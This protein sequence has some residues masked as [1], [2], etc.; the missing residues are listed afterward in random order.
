MCLGRTKLEM[1]QT[2]TMALCLGG[3][4]ML[5]ACD[6]TSTNGNSTDELL[7]TEADRRAG[8]DGRTETDRPV[9]DRPAPVDR[10]DGLIDRVEGID[11]ERVRNHLFEVIEHCGETEGGDVR[12]RCQVLRHRAAGIDDATLKRRVIH[13]YLQCIR[14]EVRPP[15]SGPCDHIRA[16]AAEVEDRLLQAELY[17]DFFECQGDRPDPVRDRCQ[18]IRYRAA[19][20]RD[21]ALRDRVYAHYF[22]C[23]NGDAPHPPTAVCQDLRARAASIT[24]RDAA[25]IAYRTYFEC[26]DRLAPP[27]PS[28]VSDRCEGLLERL[29]GADR[30]DVDPA[31][32]EEVLAQ[33]RLC[34]AERRE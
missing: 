12:N 23:A 16:R 25:L 21:P 22:Q 8:T 3:A 31:I 15:A 1:R 20:L 9:N 10:C 7:G 26:L 28:D 32:T 5:F 27:P 34:L 4:F 11:D 13:A 19:T 18:V 33:Y 2:T 29:E 14:D 24:E 17:R 6:A 30:G